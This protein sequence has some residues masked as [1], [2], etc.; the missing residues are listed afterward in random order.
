M[1]TEM[2]QVTKRYDAVEVLKGI[3]LTIE[4]GQ[5]VAILGPSGCGKTTLLRLLAG[6]DE[7]TSGE[8]RIGG[9][10]VGKAGQLV[11]PEQRHIGMVFQSFAL[12]PHL[13]VG[14]HVR[15]PL[16]HQRKRMAA[17]G[18]SGASDQQRIAEVLEMVGLAHLENRMPHEL[19]GGQ[20]QRVAFARAVAAEP[21][22]LL[23][24][25]PLSSLD[26]MLRHDMRREIQNLHRLS[27]ASIVYVTHDQSEAMAMADQV[28]VMNNGRIEQVGTPRDVYLTPA[29]EFVAQFVGKANMVEGQWEGSLFRP[30]AV[31]G[32]QP[33][34]YGGD[35]S[36][37]L[38][39]KGLFPARPDQLRISRL[40]E[41]EPGADGLRGRIVN[42]QYQGKEIHY[43]VEM[44]SSH[45]VVHAGLDEVYH[46]GDEI[47]INVKQATPKQ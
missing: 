40:D 42:V 26:A 18:G 34:W 29:T 19:S 43:T 25:E 5:F 24:D 21:S 22:L 6:F 23:M 7:P 12:W 30:K 44:S 16:R 35:V 2:I 1:S 46:H 13:C 38:R 11:P 31:D 32:A 37:L 28:V 36:P 20:K 8:I 4:E 9:I 3:Q 15:Y 33:V 14:E 39:E 45:W 10:T 17:G 27:G 47:V 41:M